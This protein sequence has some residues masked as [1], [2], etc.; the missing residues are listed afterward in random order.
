MASHGAPV[1]DDEPPAAA[2]SV[3][4]LVR[5]GIHTSRGPAE[6]RISF[7]P[8]FEFSIRTLSGTIF[9]AS[10]Q[11]APPCN[12]RAHQ[13]C[14]DS[15]GR[16]TPHGRNWPDVMVATAWRDGHGGLVARARSRCSLGASASRRGPRPP[17]D[18]RCRLCVPGDARRQ[19]RAES[20]GSAEQVGEPQELDGL[21]TQRTRCCVP[22]TRCVVAKP[23]R[24]WASYVA[25]ARLAG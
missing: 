6:A 12:R 21:G 2:T 4:V 10:I 17:R 19:R 20:E 25:P 9:S 15:K 13:R 1:V 7:R 11:L 24:T 23:Q 22:E 3:P 8:V 5:F 16:Q 18:L 14:D